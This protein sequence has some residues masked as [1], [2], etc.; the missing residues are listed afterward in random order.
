MKSHATNIPTSSK[1]RGRTGSLS[2]ISMRLTEAHNAATAAKPIPARAKMSSAVLKE[3]VTYFTMLPDDSEPSC[4]ALATAARL[5]IS[6]PAPRTQHG[7]AKASLPESLG[8]GS[9]G[10]RPPERVLLP[11][12]G[13]RDAAGWATARAHAI[14][15]AAAAGHR[16]ERDGIERHARGGARWVMRVGGNHATK[17]RAA[18]SLASSGGRS[19]CEPELSRPLTQHRMSGLQIAP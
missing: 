14:I 8:G 5:L 1:R 15:M 16:R 6:L 12:G 4:A 13:A 11:D 18:A 10:G 17:T 9:R 7:V 2:M 19:R 3:L